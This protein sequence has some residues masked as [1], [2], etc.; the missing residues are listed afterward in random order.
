MPTHTQP[1]YMTYKMNSQF[2]SMALLIVL[3][4][5]NSARSLQQ[6]CFDKLNALNGCS[7]SS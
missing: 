7:L 2:G 6:S 3:P 5:L 4:S 1:N